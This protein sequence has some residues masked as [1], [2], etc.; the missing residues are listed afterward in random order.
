MIAAPATATAN[1]T[2]ETIATASAAI[3][4]WFAKRKMAV[5]SRKLAAANDYRT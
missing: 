2:A 4:T 5:E 3:K 1:V